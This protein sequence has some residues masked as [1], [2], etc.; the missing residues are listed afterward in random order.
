MGEW[1]T[2]ETLPEK[3]NK[4]LLLLVKEGRR[5]PI[6][7]HG[8]FDKNE[9]WIGFNDYDVIEF[10]KTRIVGWMEVPMR[11]IPPTNSKEGI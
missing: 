10:G 2:V 1:K 6:I 4:E 8:F 7:I 3:H 5:N 9:G 11:K